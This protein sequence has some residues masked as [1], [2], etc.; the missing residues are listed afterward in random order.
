MESLQA[1]QSFARSAELLNFSEAARRL[2]I[3]PAAVSKNVAQLERN[4]GTQLFFRSTRSLTLTEA[5][6][7]LYC[8]VAAHLEGIQHALTS[9]DESRHE[10]SGR[11]KVSVS[12]FFGNNRVVPMLVPL[13][14]RYPLIEPELHFEN[15][16][17]DLIAEGLDVAIGGG[18]ELTPGVVARPLF[19][20][21]LIALASP[22]FLQN[23]PAPQHPRDLE[24]LDGIALRSNKS[25]RLWQWEL[26]HRD[27][28]VYS[29]RLKAKYIMDDPEALC[30]CAALGLGITV[31]SMEAAYD[32]LQRGELVRVLPDWSIDMGSV[33]VYF[34]EKKR[35]PAKT[36]VFIDMLIAH[37]ENDLGPKLSVI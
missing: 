21:H 35:L 5:G 13:K 26:K 6:E 27:G 1:L 34:A 30:R 19:K 37:F 16:H 10:P 4:L 17:V 23:H 25:R 32:Y 33:N 3:S 18:A 8:E 12:P 36:R 9:V 22:Q 11:L 31:S 14:E 28:E 15:R 24:P 20:L 2:G 7:R 29:T